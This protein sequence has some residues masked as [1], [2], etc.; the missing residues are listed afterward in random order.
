MTQDKIKEALT[1]IGLALNACNNTV[2]TDIEGKQEDDTHW[3][4]NNDMEIR[5]ICM[6]E[7]AL[8]NNTDTCPLCKNCN[9]YP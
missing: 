8:I 3:R 2:T 6:L 4:I 7:D 9:K 5:D 1:R